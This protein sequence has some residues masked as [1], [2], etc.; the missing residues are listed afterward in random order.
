ML[1][2]SETTLVAE[3]SSARQGRRSPQDFYEH[4]LSLFNILM[5]CVKLNETVQVK[6]DLKQELYKASTM[7]AFIAGLNQ[8]LGSTIRSMRS[9]TIEEAFQFI[10]EELNILY[11]Q[12]RNEHGQVDNYPG[13]RYAQIPV[14]RSNFQPVQFMSPQFNNREMPVQ[15]FRFAQPRQPYKFNDRPPVQSSYRMPSRTQQMFGAQPP[16]YNPK[17]NVFRMPSRNPQKFSSSPMSGVRQFT[18][19]ALPP[20]GHDWT[21]HGNPPPSNYFRAQEVNLNESGYDGLYTGYCDENY[22]FEPDYTYDQGYEEPIYYFS[23]SNYSVDY[24]D[25][26]GSDALTTDDVCAETQP[27]TSCN[28]NFRNSSISKKPV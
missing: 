21:K 6:I 2:R 15:G 8:P 23:D 28:E 25:C 17:S 3:L 4:C 19:R 13:N 12:R 14:P 10:Q 7:K 11:L 22:Y 27:S 20:T 16:N 26:S 9:S 24:N 1:I 5:N 18:P